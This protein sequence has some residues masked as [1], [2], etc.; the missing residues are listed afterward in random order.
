[1]ETITP[2]FDEAPGHYHPSMKPQRSMCDRSKMSAN[3]RDSGYES[4]AVAVIEQAILDYFRLVRGG[5]VRRGEINV[6]LWRTVFIRDGKQ[7][8][9]HAIKDMTITDAQEL[10]AFLKNVDGYAT[11]IG[12]DR[13]WRDLWKQ[14]LRLE[15]TGNYRGFLRRKEIE[16]E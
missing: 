8:Q 3:S 16:D 7:S 5:A 14:V 15:V 12:L 2:A 11:A 13:D 4:L 6:R 10:I 9:R 1:M